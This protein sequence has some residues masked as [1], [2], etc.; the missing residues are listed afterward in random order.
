MPFQIPGI[1]IESDNGVCIK[2]VTRTAIAIPIGSGVADTPVH[3]IEI[4]I[5]GS[6]CPNRT[7]ASLPGVTAPCLAAGLTG[8]RNR[9]KAPELLSIRSAVR[10]D[11]TSNT[12]FSACRAH[13]NFV[14]HDEGSCLLY[15]SP[16]PR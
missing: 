9:V 16:S 5:V 2:I 12:V 1:R 10:R 14:F 7:A 11:E 15:T 13:D 4:R 3:Q 6:G 8:R